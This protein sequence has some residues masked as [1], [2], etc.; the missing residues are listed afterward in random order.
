MAPKRKTKSEKKPELG[1]ITDPERGNSILKDQGPVSRDAD[2]AERPVIHVAQIYRAKARGEHSI[3]QL[4]AALDP[5]FARD[6]GGNHA[7]EPSGALG[8]SESDPEPEPESEPAPQKEPRVREDVTQRSRNRPRIEIRR[9]YLPEPR[10]HSLPVLYRNLRYVKS[11]ICRDHPDVYHITGEVYFL[12]CILPGKRT[13][14][15]LHDFIYLDRFREGTEVSAWDPGKES[16]EEERIR[17]KTEERAWYRKQINCWS[18]KKKRCEK[19][20]GIRSPQRRA[21]YLLSYWFWHRIPFVRC[22]KIICVSETVQK[23]LWERFPG[24]PR[25]K[26][27]VIPNTVGEAYE[28]TREQKLESLEALEPRG[29]LESL[30]WDTYPGA[31]AAVLETKPTSEIE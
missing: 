29:S 27:C 1:K 21:Q 24:L 7:V 14:L 13:V 12:G 16:G 3:E 4:F 18:H 6:A 22:S 28:T 2:G 10:Y 15:T 19:R 9:Y 8:E 20:C 23:D 25:E 31:R 30:C 5:W 26:T 17:S 11:V